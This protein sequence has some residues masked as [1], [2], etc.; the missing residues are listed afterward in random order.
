MQRHPDYTQQRLKL[1]A[2]R[3]KQRIYPETRPIDELLIAGPTD[4]IPLAE[5]Q[6]LSFTPARIGQSLGP[7]WATFWFKG[8]TVIPLSWKSKRIDLLWESGSEATLWVGGRSVQGLN[9]DPAKRYGDDRTDAVLIPEAQGGETL[10]FQVEMACNRMFGEGYWNPPDMSMRSFVLGRCDVGCLDPRAWELYYDFSVLQQLCAEEPKDLDKTWAGW[11]LAELNRFANVYDG[12]DRGT[13]PEGAQILKALYRNHNATIV[14]EL[15]AIGHAHIDTAWLW[16]LAET[17][18]K[19]ERTFST[20][21]TYMETYPEFKFACSQAQQYAWIKERNPDLWERI[22]QKVQSGQFIPVGGTWIE[23]DCNI[24][25]GESLCRQF[26][27]GQ[28]FFQQEFGVICREFWNPDVFGYNGQLP[29]I[30]GLAGIKRFLTQK[31]SW[32]RMNKPH[33][34]TFIWEGIDGSEL[35][36]HFPPADTYNAV[37]SIAQLRDNARNYKDHDRSRESYMLFGFGDGGG[38]PTKTMLETL[39]RARDLQGLPRTAIRTPSEFFDRLERDNTNCARVIGELYFE[40]HRGTYTTQAATKRGNRKSEQLLHDVEFL[41][42][43]A[44]QTSGRAYPAAELDRLWKLLLLNQFHDILPGSSIQ[45]VYQDAARHFAQIADEGGRL[46]DSALDALATPGEGVSP[47]N[48][49]GFER[50]EVVAAPGGQF[51]V[52][53]AGPYGVG[54]INSTA[55]DRAWASDQG[56][57]RIVLE[58]A[59]LRATLS[60]DGRLLS[61]IHRS[62]GREALAAPGNQLLMYV[63]EPNAWEAWDVDPQHMETERPCP[64]AKSCR[65]VETRSPLRAEVQFELA[66]G[67]A[68]SRLR[69]SVHLDAASPRLEFHCDCDWHEQHRLLKVAFPVNVRSMNATYDMQFGCVERPTHFN[70]RYDLAR[71]EVPGHRFADLSEHGFGV[72]LLSESKYGF[73]T[74]ANVMRMTLLRSAR[75]PDPTADLGQHAFA[76]AVMPHAG[77]W[78]EG[79]VVAEAARF[80]API[81][82]AAGSARPGSIASVDDRNLVLDT[83]KR[84]EDGDGV[85][86]RLYECHGARGVAKLHVQ[87]AVKSAVFCNILE[88]EIEPARVGDG[89][90]EIPYTPFKIVSL[91][92]RT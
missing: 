78:R 65:I 68:G 91:R 31:L 71:Y 37:V 20:Q 43:V 15:S 82:F 3:M 55:A 25:S 61:L 58:N 33:H 46:R 34:H 51:V 62:T 86:V 14:H 16:P 88:E 38:G 48:T 76:Y 87:W 74:F 49:I 84:A 90:V 79:G 29:Q 5:A 85:V 89:I 9:H 63:D 22:K 24:P 26:L 56:G 8:Q 69:Q 44:E 40:Y 23:P 80:N 66:L 18:R 19:C 57:D 92:L 13:W 36:T 83:I 21:T 30:C 72:A 28:R 7:L 4:R 10:A 27:H 12:D 50:R 53:E 35:F 75:H 17:Q 11:L 54:R 42:T 73:S 2:E 70:T 64:P 67:S 81:L 52:V 39:R 60:R 47:V 59:N 6:G 45:L 41:A 32:N 77:D 1:L